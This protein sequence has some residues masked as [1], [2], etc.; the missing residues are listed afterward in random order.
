[1]P[2]PTASSTLLQG[3]GMYVVVVL[4]DVVVVLVVVSVAVV[5]LDVV[6]SVDVVV[7]VTPHMTWHSLRAR[8]PIPPFAE[9]SL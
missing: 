4:V 5:V 1:M 2:H 3:F 9:Q 7:H 8:S 6:V